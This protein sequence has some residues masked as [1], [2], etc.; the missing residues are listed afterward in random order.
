VDVASGFAFGYDPT[1]RSVI[2]KMDRSTQ[3]KKVERP[4]INQSTISVLD[5]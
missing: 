2:I 1:G 3:L 5:M 4:L